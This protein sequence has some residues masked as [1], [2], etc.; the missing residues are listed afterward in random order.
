MF[1]KLFISPEKVVSEKI[2]KNTVEINS[3]IEV[4]IEIKK[5]PITIGLIETL[6]NKF[7]INFGSNTAVIKTVATKIKKNTHCPERL[8]FL[9]IVCKSSTKLII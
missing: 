5:V 7:I 9:I 8:K 3:G 6:A 2:G 1:E 4:M